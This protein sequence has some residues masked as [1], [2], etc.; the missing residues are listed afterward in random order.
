MP[1]C[2]LSP[3]KL[4]KILCAFLEIWFICFSGKLCQ[5]LNVTKINCREWFSNRLIE[6][7]SL[8]CLPHFLLWNNLTCS[9]IS[10]LFLFHFWLESKAWEVDTCRGHY[11][12]VSCAVFHPRQELILSNSE[13][14][15]IRVWDMSKR[16]V[17]VRRLPQP[18]RGS[19]YT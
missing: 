15:S 19:F 5:Q 17:R 7:T 2:Q 14:K 1:F 9:S 8:R 3:A 12:N 4:Y 13:D 11:N 16:L 6:P 10:F 18:Y